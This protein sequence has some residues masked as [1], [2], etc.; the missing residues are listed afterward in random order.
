MPKG[1]PQ[2]GPVQRRWITQAEP[3]LLIK[4]SNGIG[5]DRIRL[6][7]LSGHENSKI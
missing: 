6:L 7:I 3:S 2:D 5:L 1:M 4:A